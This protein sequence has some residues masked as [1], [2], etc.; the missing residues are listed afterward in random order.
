M[1]LLPPQARL[2]QEEAGEQSTGNVEQGPY[3]LGLILSGLSE[4]E[5]FLRASLRV[6]GTM[7]LHAGL[8][9]GTGLPLAFARGTQLQLIT[10]QSLSAQSTCLYLTLFQETL[11]TR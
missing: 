4:A 1:W 10:P 7:T 8:S 6:L 11:R 2:L 5:P 9:R 3:C